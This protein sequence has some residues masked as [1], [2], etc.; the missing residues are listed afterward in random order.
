V[1]LLLC[2]EAVPNVVDGKMDL[3]GG[4]SLKGIPKNVEV[5]FLTLLESLNLRKVGQYLKCPVR[6]IRARPTRTDTRASRAAVVS[7]IGKSRLG[8]CN[9]SLL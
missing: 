5:G 8:R 9:Q 1:N 2:G 7:A 3:G 4:M 6:H